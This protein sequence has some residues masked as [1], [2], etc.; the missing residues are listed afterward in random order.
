MSCAELSALLPLVVPA[1][2]AV[3]L[4]GLLAVHRSHSAAALL[5]GA[6]LVGGVV[7]LVPAATTAPEAV[8]GLL[9]VDRFAL[10]VIGMLL[11][12]AL[13]AVVLTFGY[14]R[15]TAEIPEELY[16][17]I[18]LATVGAGVLAS[19]GHLAAVFLGLETLSVALYGA[20]GYTRARPSATAAALMYLLVA[21]ASSALFLFGA[22]LLYAG[23]GTLR[24]DGLGAALGTAPPLLVAGGGALLLVAVGFKLGAAPFHLWTPDVYQGAPAPVT[25]FVATVSKA[26]V[27]A[28]LVRLTTALGGA[29]GAGVLEAVLVLL[30]IASI[31]VGNLLAVR[32]RDLKRLLAYSSVAHMGY[33]LVALLAGGGRAVE[34][35]LVYLATY[36]VATVA[37][38]GVVAA[39]SDVDGEPSRLEAYRGLA[40]RRPLLAGTLA[41]AV[42]SLAGVPLTAGFVGKLWAVLAAASGGRWAAV[43]A[44]VAGSVVGVYYY[45]RVVVTMLRPAGEETPELPTVPAAAALVLLA[46]VALLLWFGILPSTVLA[47]VRPAVGSLV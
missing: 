34:A 31:A 40:W 22:A 41:A 33:L 20:I 39:L 42:A 28:F 16:L 8:G 21:A 12:A 6:G 3:L 27:V 25:A 47:L 1:A 46:A 9:L 10:T 2:A 38:F 4:L 19:A 29:T 43:L 44:L 32:E 14:L 15:R 24:L 35:V 36:L 7:S 23:T 37:A 13:A 11:V 18:L 30:A 17:L 45:L 26:G 5:A